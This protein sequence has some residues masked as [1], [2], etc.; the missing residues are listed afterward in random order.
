MS[1]SSTSASAPISCATSAASR[2]LSPKRI[3]WVA[4]VSFSLTIG[5]MRSPSSRS[6][7]RRALER[8]IG[9]SR[10]PAVSSTWPATM[11]N[12]RSASW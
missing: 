2:S 5:R 4:T 11:R 8:C 1:L 10:S 9:F 6:I 3:S 12:G 7:A